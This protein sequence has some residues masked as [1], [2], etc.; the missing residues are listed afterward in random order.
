MPAN[1]PPQYY[2][3]EEVFRNAQTSEEK[4]AA[5]KDMLSIMPK[6]KGTEK[7]QADLKKRI[8]KL[9]EEKEK[10]SKTKSTYNPYLIDKEGAGQVILLGYPNVGKSSIVESLSNAKVK[11]AKYPFATSL[12]TAG[13]INFED[14]QIQ[15]IDTPP[16]VPEDVP[17]PMVSA[18]FHADYLAVVIDIS[19]KDCLDQLS[20]I[21]DFL[22]NKRLIREDIPE[23]VKAYHLNDILIIAN[24]IDLEGVDENLDII[25]ELY[26]ELEI[27]NVSTK[28]NLNIEKIPK[29]LFKKLKIIR[30][31]SKA[32]GEEPDYKQPYILDK[33]SIVLDFAQ[34]IHKDFAK[35]LQK[36]NIWGSARFD[37]QS[38]AKDH[39]LEDK[40]VVELH[41]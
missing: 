27:L 14:I 41:I 9:K 8:S 38:V 34:L 39:E 35:K 23:N 1:L 13:M 24:K 37:G 10:K 29:I 4:I 17:G 12:P 26:P 18:I 20:G 31:Y 5:L 3:A 33:G 6:H 2:E 16:L 32:P 15:L 19:A 28:N 25:K 7:L 36:A 22:E 21:I 11:V 40:D 30:V